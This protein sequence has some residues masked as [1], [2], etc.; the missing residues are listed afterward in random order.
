MDISVVGNFHIFI[1]SVFNF[2]NFGT[3]IEKTWVS[4]VMLKLNLGL[5]FIVLCIC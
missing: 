2:H 1:Y 4:V 5:L 3:L